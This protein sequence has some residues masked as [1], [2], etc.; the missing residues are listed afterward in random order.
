MP[1]CTH[2]YGFLLKT[3]F[4]Q[5][6]LSLKL[7]NNASLLKKSFL[8]RFQTKSCYIYKS[9]TFLQVRGLCHA[10]PVLSLKPLSLV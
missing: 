3:S 8:Q 6:F 7:F 1:R 2:I 4:K 10:A 9:A 5:R